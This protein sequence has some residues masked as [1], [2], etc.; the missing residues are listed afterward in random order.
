MFLPSNHLLRHLLCPLYQLRIALAMSLTSIQLAWIVLQESVERGD[1]EMDGRDLKQQVDGMLRDLKMAHK[2][3]EEQLS[4]AAQDFKRQ[5]EQTL[6]RHE[7]L[8]IAYK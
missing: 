3:R 7:E 5:L 6:R 2:T 8:L 4:G 1:G